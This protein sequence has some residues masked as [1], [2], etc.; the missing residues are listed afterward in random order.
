M[1]PRAN[2]MSNAYMAAET[3]LLQQRKEISSEANW[4]YL[5]KS[6]PIA[7]QN[8]YFSG[9]KMWS[10]G[11]IVW[12]ILTVLINKIGAR[13]RWASGAISFRLIDKFSAPLFLIGEKRSLSKNRNKAVCVFMK[14]YLTPSIML[15]C[16]F[17]L[18]TPANKKKKKR[19]EKAAN[20][21]YKMLCFYTRSKWKR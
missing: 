7:F 5:I 20:I 18:E 9:W 19:T 10:A 12:A 21:L 2:G 17:L 14:I 8:H 6:T 13:R 15:R 3:K 1:R 4:F 11:D 16:N